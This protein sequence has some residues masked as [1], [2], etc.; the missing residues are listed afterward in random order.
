MDII[1]HKPN[2]L[3]QGPVQR[4]FDVFV[5]VSSNKMLKNSQLLMI[6]DAMTLLN[7]SRGIDA[8]QDDVIKWKHFRVTGRLWGESTG[9]R[10]IPLTKTSDVEL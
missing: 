6:L 5:A 3:T 1:D 9:H 4:I 8:L 7:E 10:W 2:P